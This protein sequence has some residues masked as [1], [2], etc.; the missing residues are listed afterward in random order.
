MNTYVQDKQGAEMW[1]FAF[2]SVLS[3]V[4]LATDIPRMAAENRAY[5]RDHG[6]RHECVS[7]L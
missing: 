1:L 6:R 2:R 7:C 3:I 4:D 5:R